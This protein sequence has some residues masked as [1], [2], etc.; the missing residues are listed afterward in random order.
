MKHKFLHRMLLQFMNGKSA[1]GKMIS[2]NFSPSIFRIDRTKY[3]ADI[4][5]PQNAMTLI[6]TDAE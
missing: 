3:N 6:R 1:I 4:G 2:S 5:V